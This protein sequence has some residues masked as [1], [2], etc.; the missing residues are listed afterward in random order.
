[1][2]YVNCETSGFSGQR[3]SKNDELIHLAGE[4]DELNSY[5][6]LVKAMLD[7]KYR[8][9]PEEIQKKLMK[10]MTHVS[11]MGNSKYFFCK[12]EIA[13]LE[14][15]IKRLSETLPKQVEFVLPGCNIIEAQIHI[16][17]TVARR[18][19]RWFAAVNEKQPLCQ[20]AGVYL[21][22]VSDYLFILSR[23]QAC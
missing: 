13:D 21:N 22:R 18:A 8:Q 10:L 17:R 20:N 2:N 1:M 23:Q 15:E 3:M 7:E 19:E 4:I 9:Y 6:G 11:D 5:L 16:A 12:D 14:K